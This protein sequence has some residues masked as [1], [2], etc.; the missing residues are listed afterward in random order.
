MRFRHSC[1]G[2]RRPGVIAP[3]WRG[4]T[5]RMPHDHHDDHAGETAD[6]TDMLEALEREG[7]VTTPWVR[8]AIAWLGSL[9]PA[10]PRRVIDVGSGPGV[11]AVMFGEAFPS[12][13]DRRV[14]RQ[15]RVARARP[16]ASG[17]RRARRTAS[18]PGTVR[19]ARRW[20]PSA[21]PIWSGPRTWCIT[22][23]IRRPGWPSS[24]NS[25]CR[26]TRSDGTG[27]G[28]LARGRG[29]TADALPAR[30]LRRRRPR[31]GQ[32]TGRGRR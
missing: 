22:S 25:C 18:R 11:A 10:P 26:R 15:R 29:R 2:R 24:A 17:D 31:P 7:E 5:V 28:L 3:S 14:R 30:R 19:S 16:R 12:A 32:P 8:E 13:C 1:R 27:G 9:A 20:S 23:T 21:R 4:H 6:W